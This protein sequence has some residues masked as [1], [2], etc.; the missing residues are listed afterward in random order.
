MLPKQPISIVKSKQHG[1]LDGWFSS[2]SSIFINRNI[3]V[4]KNS[5]VWVFKPKNE[6]F[7]LDEFNTLK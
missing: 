2:N 5:F 4:I 1:E 6:T 3:N 7:F